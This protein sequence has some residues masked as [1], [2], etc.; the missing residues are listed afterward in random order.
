MGEEEKLIYCFSGSSNLALPDEF[1][2]SVIQD[3]FTEGT[4]LQ[5]QC[6]QDRESPRPGSVG[7]RVRETRTPQRGE[8]GAHWES[9]REHGGLSGRGDVSALR[10]GG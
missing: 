8:S 3:M 9:V 7:G 1:L 10:P 6:S 5:I 4:E 2:H